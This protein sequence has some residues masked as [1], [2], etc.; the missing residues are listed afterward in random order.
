M[1][2]MTGYGR[3]QA[4]GSGFE[5]LVEVASVN[6]KSLDISIALPKEWSTLERPLIERLRASLSRGAVRVS[7]QI[8]RSQ[9]N[10]GLDVNDVVVH[11]TLDKLGEIARSRGVRSQMD[12]ETILRVVMLHSDQGSS[13]KS[14]EAVS[15]LAFAALDQAVG[16]FVAMRAK[17]GAALEKDLLGRNET[18]LDLVFA[19]RKQAQGSVEGYRD[20]LLQRLKQLGLALD[21]SDERL[22]KELAFFADKADVTE[23]L[24]RLESH[25]AQFNTTVVAARSSEEPVGRKLEFLIQEINREFNTIGSKANNIEVTRSVLDAKNEVERQREQVQNVE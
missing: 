21:L 7:V 18:L 11:K 13:A 19:I 10:A 16:N 5:V 2:S 12:Y 23:E 22:L 1:K 9:E 24:T 25:L 17:E 15:P 20:A 3:G 6:R 8:E 4:S 14:G